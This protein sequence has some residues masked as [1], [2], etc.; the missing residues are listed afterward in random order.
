[1]GEFELIEQIFRP[2]CLRR[3]DVAAGIGDDA[4]ILALP[5]DTQLAV[6]VDTLVEGVHFP[7]AML[8]FEIGYRAAAVNL[9]DLAAM[10]ATPRWA[11]LAL[12]I[13]VAQP[14][15]LK[16]FA[17][18]LAAA[19]GPL[20]V[21]LV[22]GDTTRGPLTI[23]VQLMGTVAA[24]KALR[25]SGAQVGDRV[26]VS[27]TLGDAAGG[28]RCYDELADHPDIRFLHR[29]FAQ[30]EARVA[31]GLALVDVASSCI[32]ISD[33][34][35]ADAG[36]LATASGL[37]FELRAPDLPLSEALRSRFEPAAALALAATGGDDYELC[38]TVPERAIGL[39]ESRLEGLDCAV[40][41]VGRVLSGEGVQ[42]R[43]A[44]GQ[45]CEFALAGYRHF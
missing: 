39:L 35:L 12:T 28:L 18:G 17:R 19:L 32:D 33:G 16:A 23:S 20:G 42:L 21:A 15:W 45:L 27:G 30:P 22:G 37:A 14:D 31:L 26:F 10:A 34:L 29:R 41:E 8:P 11:T 5:P 9:S 25:R 7:A 1:M 38:F 3:D 24:G 6:C 36:H 44:Q 40:T 4:A 13:P 2:L 43:D